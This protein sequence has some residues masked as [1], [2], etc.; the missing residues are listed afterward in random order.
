MILG[1]GWKLSLTNYDTLFERKL[2][3][4]VF[5]G[6][7]S[8]KSTKVLLSGKR[9]DLAMACKMGYEQKMG[10]LHYEVTL[11]IRTMMSSVDGSIFIR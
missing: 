7:L 4:A 1:S 11:A 10:W 2:E 3:S 9:L 8:T 6:T 5:T